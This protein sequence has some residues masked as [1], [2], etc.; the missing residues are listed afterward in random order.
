MQLE[1]TAH[2]RAR[3]FRAVNRATAIQTQA[4]AAF[5]KASDMA[6]HIPLGQPILVGHHSESRDRRYRSRIHSTMIKGC[7]L[8]KAASRLTS[9][10]AS[11]GH[12]IM[13]DD[14]EAIAALSAKLKQLEDAQARM[15]AANKLVKKKDVDGLRNLGFSDRTIANLL[16]PDFCGRVGF[17]SY[18]TSNNNANIRRIRERIAFLQQQAVAPVMKPIVGDGWTI[19]EDAEDN[20]IHIAFDR[21]HDDAMH[22]KLR[23]AGFKWSP[24]R[25][26]YVRLRNPAA[27]WA[28]KRVVGLSE[29]ACQAP[30]DSDRESVSA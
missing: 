23:S 19:S 21:A 29:S 16:E 20:R 7:E 17:P 13:S 8:Q 3:K 11:A 12:A 14:P 22:A 18:A 15:K 25:N 30:S 28:A 9:A 1:M 4:D 5:R 26:A 6:A 10:A 27:I 24:T 2:Q